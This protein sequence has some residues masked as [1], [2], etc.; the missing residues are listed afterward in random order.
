M[1]EQ[2]WPPRSKYRHFWVAPYLKFVSIW[3]TIIVVSFILVLNFAWFGGFLA[4]IAWTTPLYIEVNGQIFL[5]ADLRCSPQTTIK[6]SRISPFDFVAYAYEMHHYFKLAQGLRY[7]SYLEFDSDVDICPH[8]FS[9][10]NPQNLLNSFGIYIDHASIMYIEQNSIMSALVEE[11]GKYPE[12]HEKVG[13]ISI[14]K[15][16]NMDYLQRPHHMELS[17]K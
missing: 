8:A 10:S 1:A 9:H 6:K 4:H 14:H 17:H 5:R 16:F 11:L 15:G 7:P 3:W 2:I 12:W 13:N